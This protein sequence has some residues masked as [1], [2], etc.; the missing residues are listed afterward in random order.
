VR[1]GDCH[2]GCS[3]HSRL[4][5]PS[6]VAF[7]SVRLR[8][9]KC[10]VRVT[11]KI[12]S[13][14]PCCRLIRPISATLARGTLVLICVDFML[15][16][17]DGPCGVETFPFTLPTS[18]LVDIIQAAVDDESAR[19]RPGSSRG[20]GVDSPVWCV[21]TCTQCDCVKGQTRDRQRMF[22]KCGENSMPVP[23]L[24]RALGSA[25]HLPGGILYNSKTICRRRCSRNSARRW[26]R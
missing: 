6:C 3:F 19:S 4:A 22:R 11:G 7:C 20:G 9:R 2:H 5:I 8:H 10:A 13:T 25:V 16:H 12:E 15:L 17:W 14:W 1:H 24:R 21:A 26:T 18:Y 23:V